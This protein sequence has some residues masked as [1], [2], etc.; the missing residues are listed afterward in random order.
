MRSKRIDIIV[1]ISEKLLND[2]KYNADAKG[3]GF[4]F[5]RSNINRILKNYE[6][7]HLIPVGSVYIVSPSNVDYLFAYNALIAW[8]FGN[9]VV[10]KLPEN[11]GSNREDVFAVVNLINQTCNNIS[12]KSISRTSQ[13][14][15]SRLK[16]SDSVIIWGG[17]DAVNNIRKT[18][19]K[20]TA[21][22]IGFPDRKSGSVFNL[23]KILLSEKNI[24]AFATD[25]LSQT[26]LAC[27]SPSFLFIEKF[28]LDNWKL[29]LTKLS[30][31]NSRFDRKGWVQEN[32]IR[33]MKFWNGKKLKT[34]E[35]FSYEL[36]SINEISKAIKNESCGFGFFYIIA[37]DNIKELIN[38]PKENEWQ[39]LTY[40]ESS[41]N[42][43]ELS[44]LNLIGP[45]FIR[46]KKIGEALSFSHIWDGID[47]IRSVTIELND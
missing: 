21:R 28:T 35:G 23:E 27:S 38:I 47:L 7:T 39:T 37:V 13:E 43:S 42:R 5:R 19:I 22:I 20:P 45:R 40:D 15:I 18:E 1:G 46:L 16:N 9:E 32:M 8:L 11:I 3:L 25:V 33:V 26:Q 30:L 10:V 31:A 24:K 4:F 36:I 41:L 12:I 29:F 6:N 2:S 14:N 17:N 34:H 44:H